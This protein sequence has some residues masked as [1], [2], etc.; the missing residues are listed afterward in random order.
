MKKLNILQAK[1]EWL[2]EFDWYT[3]TNPNSMLCAKTGSLHRPTSG[4]HSDCEVLS[5]QRYGEESTFRETLDLL[6]DCHRL[7]PFCFNNGNT[8]AAIART[9]VL[10]FDLSDNAAIVRSAEGHYVAGVL[11]DDELTTA[12]SEITLESET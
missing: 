8:F 6:L 5:N 4:G 2:R 1:A 12:L 11:R 10:Q 7:S 3:V 9:V